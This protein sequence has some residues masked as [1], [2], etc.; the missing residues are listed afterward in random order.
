MRV[1]EDKI[2]KNINQV[3][4]RSFATEP[5]FALKLGGGWVFGDVMKVTLFQQSRK[6]TERTKVA[7]KTVCFHGN[8]ASAFVVKP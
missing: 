4:E 1:T 5:A 8:Q 3:L 2:I 7:H 6:E